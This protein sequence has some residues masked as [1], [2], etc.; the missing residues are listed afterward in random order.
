METTPY[1]S[2]KERFAPK[3][4]LAMTTKDFYGI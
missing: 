3:K 4:G 2:R 1:L